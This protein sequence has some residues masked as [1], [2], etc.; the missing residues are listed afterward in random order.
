[1]ADNKSWV[2]FGFSLYGPLANDI[3]A[4][5][6][7]H[8]FVMQKE[9]IYIYI[10]HINYI[11]YAERKTP[12]TAVAAVPRSNDTFWNA[13]TMTSTSTSRTSSTDDMPDQSD[14]ATMSDS[15]GQ[16]SVVTTNGPRSNSSTVSGNMLIFHFV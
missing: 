12:T 15:T 14:A 4:C 3:P 8:F 16:I 2:S 6:L 11:D 5:L 7:I 13:T 10:I 1:M 9:T